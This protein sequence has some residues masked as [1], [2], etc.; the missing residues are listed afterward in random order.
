MSVYGQ[1]F[2]P[3]VA[4]TRPRKWEASLNQR[5]AKRTV[6]ARRRFP[7]AC[8]TPEDS[9]APKSRPFP[10]ASGCS[11]A[12]PKEAPDGFDVEV[13]ESIS[14]FGED[15]WNEL[16]R[17]GSGLP[18][19]LHGF[20]SA[21]EE[22][23][24]AC[25][26]TGWIPRHIA[27]RGENGELVAVA[28]AYLKVHSMGEFVFDQQWAEAAYSA[29]INYYPKLLLAVP[30][31]PATGRRILTTPA[32]DA[33]GRR[34]EL[35][36]K[37]ALALPSVCEALQVSSVHVNFCEAEEADV[38]ELHG[39]LRR[40]GTQFHFENWTRDKDGAGRKYTSFDDYLGEFRA[41]RRGN[42]RRERRIVRE[43]SGLSVEVVAG[44]EIDASMMDEMFDVYKSTI[45]KL[46]WGRQ[47]LNREFFRLL[48]RNE[49]FREHLV[50][51]IARR[52]CDLKMVAATFNVISSP[53]ATASSFFGRYWGCLE[54]RKFLHY[55]VCYYSA[56]EFCIENGL[57]RMEPGAGGG[58]FKY[59]RGFEP[60]RTLSMHYIRDRRLSAAVRRFL[61]LETG[62]V[63]ESVSEM[64]KRS[65][66]K[67][68]EN[69]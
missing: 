26:E 58:D 65:P 25:I 3:F 33:A 57:S 6:G 55:E 62:Y 36:T 23:T 32:I 50:F 44:S 52:Q 24:C 60:E 1:A 61:I 15:E 9:T 47:Y 40:T 12:R 14:D 20:L 67:R 2:V 22:S 56:I 38:L 42:I 64:K 51:V 16:A 4:G 48:L 31:T 11:D 63:D 66:M 69:N 21:L 59:Q 41:K 13:H 35:L 49:E 8:T 34:T 27:L 39:F 68:S 54:E 37:F 19:L 17:S 45:D 7:R 46:F 10:D 53:T 18:F 28:P 30:F 29:G 43:Q 5:A